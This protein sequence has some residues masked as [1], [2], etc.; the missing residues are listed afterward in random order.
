MDLNM[1]VMDGIEATKEIIKLQRNKKIDKN[2][3][4]VAVTAFAS[5]S[6]KEK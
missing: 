5:E 2:L 4:I 3:K 6:E 1:P